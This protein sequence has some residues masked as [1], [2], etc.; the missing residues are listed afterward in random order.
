M[1]NKMIKIC[2]AHG[3]GVTYHWW[4]AFVQPDSL[5]DLGV[6]KMSSNCNIT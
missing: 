6:N 1:V 4:S 5:G 3:T 2:G